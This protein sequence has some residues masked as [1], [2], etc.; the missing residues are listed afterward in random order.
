MDIAIIG[1]GNIAAA[2]AGQW[3]P[4]RPLPRTPRNSTGGPW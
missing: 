3:T 4:Y 1:T 2:L